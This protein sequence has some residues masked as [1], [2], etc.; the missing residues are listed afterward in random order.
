MPIK[1]DPA[2][3]DEGSG[4]EETLRANKAQYHQ[5]CSFKCFAFVLF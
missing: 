1:L 2:R 4:V 3:L 5:S